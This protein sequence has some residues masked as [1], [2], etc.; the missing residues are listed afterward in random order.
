MWASGVSSLQL[1]LVDKLSCT[2]IVNLN[3]LKYW[4]KRSAC[5]QVKAM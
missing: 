4:E 1:K 5:L 2:S 3:P